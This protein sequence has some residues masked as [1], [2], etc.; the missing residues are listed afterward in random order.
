MLAYVIRIFFKITV[1]YLD[2]FI[3]FVVGNV[4]SYYSL[5]VSCF[6]WAVLLMGDLLMASSWCWSRT[7]DTGL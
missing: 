7:A 6:W 3:V 1:E 5:M 2:S 4:R